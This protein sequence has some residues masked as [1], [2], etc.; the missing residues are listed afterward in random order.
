M[1]TRLTRLAGNPW[2]RLGL[3]ALVLASCGY[4]L[5]A[6]WPQVTAGMARLHWYSVGLALAAAM[7][8]SAC[9]MLAWRAILADLGSPL[10]V[11]CAAKINFVAQLG[12]YLPGA[13]WSLAAQ[14]ELGHDLGVPRRRSGAS[15]AVSLVVATGAGLGVAAVALPLASPVMARNYWWALA[16]VPLIAACLCPPVLGRIIDRILT[17][18][19]RQPL[20]RRPTWRGLGRALA[21]TLAGW[22]LLGFQVWLILSTVAGH[23]GNVLLA[24]GGYALAFCIGLLLVIFPSGI[25][26]REVILIAALAT[27]VP[28]GA[29]VAIALATRVVTTGSDLACGGLGFTLGRLSQRAR[30]ILAQPDQPILAQPT[31]V[32]QHGR[33]RKAA[34]RPE[35]PAPPQLNPPAAYP[36]ESAAS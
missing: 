5:Y 20:E 24:T 19:R 25:G 22:A 9:M 35:I 11:A 3:L 8:G 17:L 29:A 18:A 1:L 28:H 6:Q 15:F 12:K 14:I 31:P 13:V 32:G 30:P 4:G 21:W 27:A 16:A 2:L 34:A 10:P 7:A 26:A 36:A 23:R 33:H